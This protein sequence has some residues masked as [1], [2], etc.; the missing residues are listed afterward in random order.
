M[1]FIGSFLWWLIILVIWVAVAFWP[2]PARRV[3]RECRSRR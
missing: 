3:L 2:A 1:L